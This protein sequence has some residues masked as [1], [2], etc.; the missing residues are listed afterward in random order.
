MSHTYGMALP[1]R[2]T[3]VLLYLALVPAPLAALVRR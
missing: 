2:G 1:I 3:L